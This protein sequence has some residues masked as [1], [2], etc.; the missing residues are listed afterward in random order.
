MHRAGALEKHRNHERVGW[1][2]ATLQLRIKN[3]NYYQVFG[4]SRK[5]VKLRIAGIA[6]DDCYN[7]NELGDV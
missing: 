4:N 1:V 7:S 6:L 2:A 3:R 5:E